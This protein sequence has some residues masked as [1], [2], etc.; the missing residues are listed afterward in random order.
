M[1]ELKGNY[2]IYFS[3]QQTKTVARKAFGFEDLQAC[4]RFEVLT[5]PQHN[6]LNLMIRSLPADRGTLN[7]SEKLNCP[8]VATQD[9]GFFECA[10]IAAEPAG[11]PK[12]IPF[13]VKF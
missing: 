9:L 5:N 8:D 7:S 6:G 1:I 10:T 2:K 11:L 13:A 4:F 12:E 3:F